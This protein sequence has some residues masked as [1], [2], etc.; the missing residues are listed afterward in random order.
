MTNM[1]EHAAWVAEAMRLVDKLALATFNAAKGL[2]DNG[3]DTAAA[4]SAHLAAHP[5]GGGAATLADD[6]I[7]TLFDIA[8]HG[9][10]GNPTK[11]RADIARLLSLYAG[12]DA[13]D[14]ADAKRYRWLR[15]QDWFEGSLCVL[16]DPRRVLTRGIGLGA[17]CPSRSRL[18]AAID[19]AMAQEPRHV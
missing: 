14:A 2:D 8:M 11:M 5:S 17:D 16:R 7:G 4:L 15:L 18:D 10:R 3:A 13:K 6:E 12:A 1:T 19:S 9:D